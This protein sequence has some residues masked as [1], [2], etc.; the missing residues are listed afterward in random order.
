M[1]MVYFVKWERHSEIR[2][3]LQSDWG[4]T[5]KMRFQC[6]WTPKTEEQNPDEIHEQSQGKWSQYWNGHF[7][8][9][10]FYRKCFRAEMLFFWVAQQSQAVR[11]EQ[12]DCITEV[13]CCFFQNSCKAMETGQYFEFPLF[14]GICL[15]LYFLSSHKPSLL[16]NLNLSLSEMICTCMIC[17]LLQP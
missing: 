2:G 16:K 8:G 5:E 1:C 6:L 12:A 10:R 4:H 9:K 13:K 3:G 15:S 7:G 11:W 17:C 14:L